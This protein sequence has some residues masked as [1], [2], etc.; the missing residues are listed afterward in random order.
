MG[1]RT[2]LKL[3]I[4][5]KIPN[6]PGMIPHHT[7]CLTDWVISAQNFVSVVLELINSIMH[8]SRQKISYFN[9]CKQ[10][11]QFLL[12]KHFVSYLLIM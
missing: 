5:G 10:I 8:A 9:P 11:G 7:P 4:K 2:S 12:P 1:C 6:L 3:V